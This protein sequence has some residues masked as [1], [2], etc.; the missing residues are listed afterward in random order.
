M[1]ATVS[2]QHAA[3]KNQPRQIHPQQAQKFTTAM[4]CPTAMC[5]FFSQKRHSM[6][7]SPVPFAVLT[8]LRQSYTSLSESTG[9]LTEFAMVTA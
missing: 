6:N 8:T 1:G 4:Q 3:D 7:P 9:G 5:R 2:C